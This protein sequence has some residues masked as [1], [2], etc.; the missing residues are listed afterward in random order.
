MHKY[1]SRSNS[2]KSLNCISI[3]IFTWL[4]INCN[5]TKKPSPLRTQSLSKT[6]QN[7]RLFGRQSSLHPPALTWRSKGRLIGAKLSN[8]ATASRIEVARCKTRAEKD[9]FLQIC[10]VEDT[11]VQL[12]NWLREG[13]KR[14]RIQSVQE[15]SIPQRAFFTR[16]ASTMGSSQMSHHPTPARP[17][18][19]YK[20]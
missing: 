1:Q 6:F 8:L 13:K 9:A 5:S 4:P 18:R 11:T 14:F 12:H 3:Q 15:C 19:R 16:F 7:L 2:K 20:R 10:V 17:L